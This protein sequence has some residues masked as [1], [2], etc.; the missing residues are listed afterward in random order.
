RLDDAAKLGSPN[1]LLTPPRVVD[2]RRPPAPPGCPRCS[3]WPRGAAVRARNS[4]S[5]RMVVPNE[6]ASVRPRGLLLAAVVF[7]VAFAGPTTRGLALDESAEASDRGAQIYREQCAA[8]HGDK[9]EGVKS[10]YPRV[11]TG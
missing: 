7:T 11:L 8:C 9:G 6:K 10:A 2:S 5:G 1:P 4:W 3:G